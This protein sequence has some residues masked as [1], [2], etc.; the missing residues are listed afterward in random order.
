MAQPELPE[1]KHPAHPPPVSRTNLSTII[2]VTV[3]VAGRRRL[4]AADVAHSLLVRIWKQT[5][6]WRVGR[7]VVMPDHV[8][9][10]CAPA[11]LDTPLK[12]WVQCWRNL[13]TRQWP[14]AED[15]PIWQRDFWDTQLRRGENYEAKWEYVRQ[16]PVRAGLVRQPDEWPY[17]GQLHHLA[18]HEPA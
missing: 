17:Q 6:K 5:E 1:R 2:M 13:A 16:N 10:F 12:A 8:H 4:L 11:D 9:L 14:C 15:K 18:W 7:Y 3:C